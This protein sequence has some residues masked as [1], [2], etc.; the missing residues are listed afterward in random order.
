ATQIHWL[1]TSYTTYNLLFLGCVLLSI[2]SRESED[3]IFMATFIDF[4]AIL[5]DAITIGLYYGS[6]GSTAFSTFMVIAN[7]LLRPI[8]SLV[9]LRFYNERSGRYTN[10]GL[11][12]AGP[13]SGNRASYEEIDHRQSVPQSVVDTGSPARDDHIPSYTPH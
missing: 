12:F 8:T 3:A 7:L 2:H 11:G 10:Y 5:L 1:P 9:L 13:S 4:A 6:N